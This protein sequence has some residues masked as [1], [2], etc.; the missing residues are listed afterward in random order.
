MDRLDT[1]KTLNVLSLAL[2]V[3]YLIFKVPWL[4]GAAMILLLGNILESRLTAT[5]ARY[6]M[7]FGSLLGRVNTQILLTVI[8]YVVLTPV[9]FL[10]RLM[11]RDEADHFRRNRRASYWDR[12]TR[13]YEKTD[14][15]KLW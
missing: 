7:K 13:S 14:F 9:A 3:F 6:W 8:F 1:I 2:L 11:N 4:L 10:F 15:H 5:L 12:V